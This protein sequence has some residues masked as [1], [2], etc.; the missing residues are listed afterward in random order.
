MAD[1]DDHLS[2][3]ASS[4]PPVDPEVL[5][6]KHNAFLVQLLMEEVDLGGPT[7]NASHDHAVFSMQASDGPTGQ[8]HGVNPSHYNMPNSKHDVQA[9]QQV[10]WAKFE[11]IDKRS[12]TDPP[13]PPQ[14]DLESLYM[15]RR[16]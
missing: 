10:L 2:E 7:P 1:V 15:I 8:V 4:I 16:G 3:I 5:T 9:L 11:C 13:A 6:L 14:E 12:L